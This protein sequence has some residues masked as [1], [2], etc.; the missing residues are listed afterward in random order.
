MDRSTLFLNEL[1]E[2]EID[3]YETE[4]DLQEELNIIVNEKYNGDFSAFIEKEVLN[5][6]YGTLRSEVERIYNSRF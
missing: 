4:K 3:K 6:D 2:Y 1:R 5:E